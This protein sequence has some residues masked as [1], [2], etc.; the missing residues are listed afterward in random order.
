MQGIGCSADHKDPTL[1]SPLFSC[2]VPVKGDR[3]YLQEAVQSLY[4]QGVGD[5]LEIIIQDGD[6]ESDSGLSDALNRGFSK[7]KGEWLFWLNADDVLLDGALMCLRD[8]IFA[9]PQSEWFAGN[10]KYLGEDGSHIGVRWNSRWHSFLYRYLAVWTGGPSSFF[11]KALWERLGGFDTSLRFMMDIDLWTRW[12]R[13]GVRYEVLPQLIWGFRVHHGSLTTGGCHDKE[14]V[15]E[16]ERFAVTQGLR[17]QKFWRLL[18]RVT[19]VAD[20][21]WWRRLR[22]NHAR[23]GV[24]A[25]VKT[26]CDKGIR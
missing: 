9:N 23:A 3:P 15:E 18:M 13:Q 17:N 4:A 1:N 26:Q 5:S 21:S 8:A 2:V 25:G 16:A 12:A 10:T 7:A 6:I 20:G 19:Q 24:L 14:L 22:L 11:K